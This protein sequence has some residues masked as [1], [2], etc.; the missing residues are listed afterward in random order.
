VSGEQI[1]YAQTRAISEA[2][3]VSQAL[4][5]GNAAISRAL[6]A[7]IKSEPDS[8]RAMA[9][10]RAYIDTALRGLPPDQRA[11]LDSAWREP[12]R[13]EQLE[14]GL[15]ITLTPWFRNI[16][17]YEPAA[18]LDSMRVPVLALF[19]GLDLQVP[20]AQSV[21]V[22][23]RLWSDHPDATIHV[24]PKLNHLFQNAETGLMAEYARIEE[25]FAVEALDMMT[26]WIL[27]RF[28]PR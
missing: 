12:G 11:A 10:M 20:P 22:L 24:F 27:R 6:Y 3:G 23:E 5:E 8:A 2:S 28:G 9:T 15:A 13:A 17:T 25:T 19:G 18:A 26:E 1:L 16:L 14:Q 21:P 7:I 4:I